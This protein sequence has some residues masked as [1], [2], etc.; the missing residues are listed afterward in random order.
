MRV[1]VGVWAEL[2]VDQFGVVCVVV[3]KMSSSAALHWGPRDVAILGWTF[4]IGHGRGGWVLSFLVEK[5]GKQ[6]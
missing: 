3:G 2:N 6:P 5:R 4:A 1:H